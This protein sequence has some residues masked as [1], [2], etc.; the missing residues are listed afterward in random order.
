MAVRSGLDRDDG[1]V[2]LPDLVDN[3]LIGGSAVHVEHGEAPEDSEKAAANFSRAV[4]VKQGAIQ[5]NII[6]QIKSRIDNIDESNESDVALL[7]E[8]IQALRVK[9]SEL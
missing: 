3:Q 2:V 9:R 1:Y 4:P 6:G 7:I 5:T 8:M